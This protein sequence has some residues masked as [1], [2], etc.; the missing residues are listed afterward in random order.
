MISRVVVINRADRP[1]RLAAFTT[2]WR[3]SFLGHIAFDVFPAV[4]TDDGTAGCLASHLGVLGTAAAQDRN[5]LVLEDDACFTRGFPFLS[6]PPADW[7]VLW[8]GGEHVAAPEPSPAAGWVRPIEL[9]RT[10]AYL[11][12]EPTRVLELLRRSRPPRADPYIARLRLNQFVVEPQTAGQV[13]G[14]SDTGGAP[15]RQD[16]YWHLRRRPWR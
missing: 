16:S 11:V 12:R 5:L 10:H 13:A 8:L 2:R 14:A 4:I 3:A 9:M 15:L 6:S 1:E 7:D